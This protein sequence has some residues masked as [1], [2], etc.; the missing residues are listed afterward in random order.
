MPCGHASSHL[1]I[2]T[3]KTSKILC[4]RW[5][6]YKRTSKINAMLP[7]AMALRSNVTRKCNLT[8]TVTHPQPPPKIPPHSGHRSLANT[9]NQALTKT[10]VGAASPRLHGH[11]TRQTSTARRAP[12]AHAEPPPSA[13]ARG[14]YIP[15]SVVV[16]DAAK[17]K[18]DGARAPQ[19]TNVDADAAKTTHVNLPAILS[20][21]RWT[22][23]LR[24][25]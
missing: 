25:C 1:N 12:R 17:P 15:V 13:S 18:I 14:G 23:T 20:K 24:T 4:Q 9:P 3:L 8:P 10:A 11:A 19:K 2:K 7:V 21:S 16:A 6:R 5:L 22:G